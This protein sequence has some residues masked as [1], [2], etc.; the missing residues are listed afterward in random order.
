MNAT[1]TVFDCNFPYRLSETGLDKLTQAEGLL[2]A[3]SQLAGQAAVHNK[4]GSIEMTLTD[5][6][7]VMWGIYCL[8]DDTLKELRDS[9]GGSVTS[10]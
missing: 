7:R 4:H 1:P 8:V 2:M 5:L 10:A 6:H 9:G 3:L